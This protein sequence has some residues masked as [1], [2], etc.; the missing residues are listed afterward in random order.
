MALS[1]VAFVLFAQLD[2]HSSYATG[3]LPGLLVL[4]VGV[5]LVFAPATDIATRG[6]STADAGVA[7][8]LV[9]A[10]NQVGGSLGIALLSTFSAT[11][12]THY[13]AARHPNPSVIAHAAVH[14]YTTAFWWAAGIFAAG[15]LIGAMLLRPGAARLA[16]GPAPDATPVAAY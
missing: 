12:A 8:A 5:G 10:T 9:N 1:A 14:G 15:A 2:V 7:S 3:V 6:V 13:L 4:G 16:T 11:A